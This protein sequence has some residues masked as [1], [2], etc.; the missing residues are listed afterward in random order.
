M[1]TANSAVVPNDETRQ[2][3]FF[4][5]SVEGRVPPRPRMDGV[6][7]VPPKMSFAEITDALPNNEHVR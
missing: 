5:L 7:A 6:E 4:P 2:S 1:R 3:L